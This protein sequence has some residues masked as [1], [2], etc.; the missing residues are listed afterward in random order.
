MAIQKIT[1]CLW[2]DS[3]A[4]EAA[5]FYTSIFKNSSIGNI[6]RF[7]KEGFEFHGK[8]EGAVMTVSFTL[9]GQLFTALNGGPIFTF[10]ESVSFMVGCDTQNE[11]DYYWNKLTEGGQESNCGWLKDKFG[12][13]WQIIPNILSK[14]MTDPEKA[15]RV[16]QAFLQMKK[17][18]IQK[19]MEC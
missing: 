2:F 10:N 6:S 16:T 3:Q 7:G 5:R 14:L 19:L 13:S 8:P 1:P 18:D 11:I 9:D 12:V 15:P 4:E 17:F